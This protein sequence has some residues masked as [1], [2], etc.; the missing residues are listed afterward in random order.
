MSLDVKQRKS[1]RFA[2]KTNGFYNFQVN[3]V[4]FADVRMR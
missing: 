4:I 3:L 1:I 2:T